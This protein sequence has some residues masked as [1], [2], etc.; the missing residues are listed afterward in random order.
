VHIS[1]LELSN[2]RNFNKLA[3]SRLPPALVVLGENGVGK[4]NLLAALRLVLDPA[5]PDTARGLDAVSAVE[6]RVRRCARRSETGGTHFGHIAAVQQGDRRLLLL[7]GF[8]F[9]PARSRS[10]IPPAYVGYRACDQW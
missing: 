4:S 10:P 8:G 6:R 7:L 5:F 3:L 9:R 2:Y 1:A